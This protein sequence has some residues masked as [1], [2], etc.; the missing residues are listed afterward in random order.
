MRGIEIIGVKVEDNEVV[1]SLLGGSDNVCGTL[2]FYEKDTDKRGKLMREAEALMFG[3]ILVDLAISVWSGRW[4]LI[5]CNRQIVGGAEPTKLEISQTV[6]QPVKLVDLEKKEIIE[7]KG[8]L[9]WP[10]A[11]GDEE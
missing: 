10:E 8:G 2:R 9:G 6:T 3:N 7:D 11:W 1:I 4:R 5:G